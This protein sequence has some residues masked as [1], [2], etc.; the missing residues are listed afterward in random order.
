MMT[1]MQMTL[2]RIWTKTIGWNSPPGREISFL[3]SVMQE[4]KTWEI[5]Y[6]FFT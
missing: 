5:G 1:I 2:K 4:F 6:E 3:K